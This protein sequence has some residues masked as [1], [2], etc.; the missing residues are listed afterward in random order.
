[1]RITAQEHVELMFTAIDRK[2]IV[3]DKRD[4]FTETMRIYLRGYSQ[5]HSR[6]LI[7]AELRRQGLR[8]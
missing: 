4:Y 2:S 6:K 1:M 7:R 8:K 3:I 5:G